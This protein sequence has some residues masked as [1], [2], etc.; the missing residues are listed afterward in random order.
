MDTFLPVLKTLV[1]LTLENMHEDRIF[2][3]SLTVMI[4]ALTLWAD[5]ELEKDTLMETS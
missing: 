2:L 3:L 1:S 4:V 5:H